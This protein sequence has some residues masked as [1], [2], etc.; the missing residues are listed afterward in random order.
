MPHTKVEVE[1]R[2]RRTLL[3]AGVNSVPIDLDQIAES[4][5]LTIRYEPM[6]DGVSGFLMAKGNSGV[7]V[8]NDTH[9]INRKRFTIAHEI[10]HYVLHYDTAERLFYDTKISLYNRATVPSG[11]SA[12]SSADPV[13]EKEANMFASYLLMPT[14]ELSAVF[15]RKGMT[16]DDSDIAALA[17]LFRVS[18]IA[19][20]IRL[21]KLDLLKLD[22]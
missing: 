16:G 9:H 3:A 13:E 6:E 1:D 5:Q 7:V 2:A 21:Q 22:R 15:N 10:G 20:S 19:M 18:E 17:Q 12:P 11:Q 14:K 4:N 8:I